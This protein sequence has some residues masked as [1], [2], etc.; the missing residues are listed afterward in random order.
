MVRLYIIRHG[1]PDYDTDKANGGS[2]T[3]HGKAE[4]TALATFLA[5]EGITH[6]KDKKALFMS[7]I[8]IVHL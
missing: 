6:G 4:A 3:E 5:N 8:F 7:F 2:L 1:D